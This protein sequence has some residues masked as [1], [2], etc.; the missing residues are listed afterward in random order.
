M[1]GMGL[2]LIPVVVRHLLGPLGM[3]GLMA[4]ASCM[5]HS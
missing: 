1:E 5:C 2:K 3:S 4:D